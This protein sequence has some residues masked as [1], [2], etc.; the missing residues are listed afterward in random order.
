VSGKIITQQGE[1]VEDKPEETDEQ[2]NPAEEFEAIA[3]DIHKGVKK[4]RDGFLFKI[5]LIAV[6]IKIV[7]VVGKIV[8]ENQRLKAKQKDDVED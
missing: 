6:S 8:L 4:F 1:P 5:G 7:D 3:K 2:Y